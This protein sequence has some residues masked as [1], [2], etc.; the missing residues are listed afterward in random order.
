MDN[1]AIKVIPARAKIPNGSYPGLW[2]GYV[3]TFFYQFRNEMRPVKLETKVGVRGM[4]IPVNVTSN[5]GK[6]TFHK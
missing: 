1:T 2:G 4:N 6:F 3:I 5:N